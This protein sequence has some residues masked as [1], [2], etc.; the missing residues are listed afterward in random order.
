MRALLAALALLLGLAAAQADDGAAGPA[1][2]VAEGIAILAGKQVPLPPGRWETLA[3][4]PAVAGQ[5]GLEAL[6]LGRIEEGRVAGLVLAIATTRPRQSILGPSPECGRSDIF[7]AYTAYDTAYDGLCGYLNLVLLSPAVE[8]PPGWA[9]ARRALAARGIA[10]PESWLTVGIRARSQAEALE[11]RYYVPPPDA[12]AVASRGDWASHPWSPLNVAYDPARQAAI[13]RLAI[14]GAW[15]RGDVEAGLRGRLDPAALPPWPWGSDDLAVRLV[16]LRLRQLDA[17]A[18]AGAIEAAA[19]DEQRRELEAV[20]AAPERA[21]TPV[22]L[23][24]LWKTLTYRVVSMIDSFAVAYFILGDTVQSVAWAAFAAVRGPVVIYLHELG[25]TYSGYGKA[26]PALLDAGF[27]EI[28][29]D[30]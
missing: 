13:T 7:L 6:L 18:A 24:A 28:G 29:I 19:Y 21:E 26:A 4:G 8:G 9:A 11:V 5:D 22:W 14:W 23:H 12:D 16:H 1:V 10:L 25:W 30:R 20:V 27:P 3:R 15:V 2:G 17:L